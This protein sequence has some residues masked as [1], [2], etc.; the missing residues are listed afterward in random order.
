MQKAIMAARTAAAI[1][2][3][4]MPTD[5]PTPRPLLELVMLAWFGDVTPDEGVT[6]T[7]MTVPPAVTVCTVGV[8]V[9]VG[10]ELWSRPGGG[11]IWLPGG[12][13]IST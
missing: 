1:T 4:A 5:A 11:V 12:A 7:V 6:V 10:P 13:S 2:P 9:D 8:G 3:M